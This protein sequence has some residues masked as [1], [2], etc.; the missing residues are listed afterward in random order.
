MHF[1]AAIAL[2]CVVH[3]PPRNGVHGCVVINMI[4]SLINVPHAVVGGRWSVVLQAGARHFVGAMT[5]AQ[6]DQLLYATPTLR[7]STMRHSH[8]AFLFGPALRQ[9]INATGSK[10]L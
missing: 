10:L 2:Q 3:A 9:I 5:R 8:T 7:H 1:K 6:A 4:K